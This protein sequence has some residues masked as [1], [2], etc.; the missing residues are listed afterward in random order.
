MSNEKYIVE[1]IIGGYVFLLTIW[2][3]VNGICFENEDK[4]KQTR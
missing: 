2:V 3:A 4:G 1:D